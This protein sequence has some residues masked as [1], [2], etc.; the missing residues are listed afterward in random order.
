MKGLV[1]TEKLYWGIEGKKATD[2]AYVA[3]LT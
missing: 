3:M 1:Y 2:L